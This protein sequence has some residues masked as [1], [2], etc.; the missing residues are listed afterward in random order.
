MNISFLP[1]QLVVHN[2]I[3]V[4][5][6]KPDVVGI[7]IDEMTKVEPIVEVH[8]EASLSICP[9]ESHFRIQIGILVGRSDRLVCYN[10]RVD[11]VAVTDEWHVP[12]SPE[13]DV[14][15]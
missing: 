14:L 8:E 9:G 10:G 13:T 4:W 6:R 1:I 11:Q 2:L 3:H 5:I 7:R 12:Q 15:T